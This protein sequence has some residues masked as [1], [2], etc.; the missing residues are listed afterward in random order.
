MCKTTTL[1]QR[2][3]N[4][5]FQLWRSASILMLLLGVVLLMTTAA[6]AQAILSQGDAVVTGFSGIKPLDASVPPG[7]NPL[8]NFF[9]DLD[10]PSMQIVQLGAAG[11]AP[12]GRLITAPVL[13][14]VRAGDIG[15]VFA[16]ALDDA[17]PPNIYLGAT[18]AFGIQIVV[19]G[20]DGRPRRVKIGRPIADWMPGQ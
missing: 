2:Q 20:H 17:T 7:A 8:D 15:Q 11:A 3:T 12:Q 4:F 1:A 6:K 5:M 13:F 18:S 19:P 14:K 16:I 10:G 9:I